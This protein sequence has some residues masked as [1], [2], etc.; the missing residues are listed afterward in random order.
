MAL[1]AQVAFLTPRCV[2]VERP[3]AGDTVRPQVIHTRLWRVVGPAGPLP[4]FLPS[5]P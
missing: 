5:V 4:S 1:F 3:G 2:G